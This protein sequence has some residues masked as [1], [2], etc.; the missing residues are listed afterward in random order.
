MTSPG[1][2]AKMFLDM[3]KQT[4]MIEVKQ[5]APEAISPE[6]LI[7]LAIQNNTPVEVMERLLAMSKEIKADRAKE[8]FDKAMS[9][10]LSEMPVISKNQRAGSGSFTYKY[11][12]LEDIVAKVKDIIS[13]HGFS[14]SFDTK[15]NGKLKVLCKVTHAAGHTEVSEF[16]LEIDKSA[17]MN[18]S[19]QYGSALSYGKRYAFCNAFGIVIGG[20]DTDANTPK[21]KKG[22]EISQAQID[23][24]NNINTMPK[25]SSALKAMQEKLGSD[26][27]VSI[28]EHYGRRKEEIESMEADNIAEGFEDSQ[29]GK[30]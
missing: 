26:Y 5:A 1:H 9:Q 2:C 23:F 19:Q 27:T 20:E 22:K 3:K 12:P 6:K 25:L 18:I 21:Q 28:R 14:Y 8:A 10:L 13:K 30:K 24:I 15:Q 11:A 4:K 17:R 7:Q 29:K 16:E